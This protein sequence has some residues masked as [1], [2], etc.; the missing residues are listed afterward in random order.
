MGVRDGRIF[1][2]FLLEKKRPVVKKTGRAV[3]MD[4][5]YVNGFVFSDGQNVGQELVEKI[6]GFAKRTKHTHQLI[7]DMVGAELKKIDLSQIY[8]LVIEDLKW[9]KNG[10]RGKF[11]RQMNRRMSHKWP[12]LGPWL[13]AY[14]ADW[15]ARCCEEARVRLESGPSR[16]HGPFEGL[17]QRKNPAYTSQYCR[18]CNKWDRRNRTGDKFVCVSCG[19][20]D[21]ADKNASKNLELLGL[22]GVY[23][24][25]LLQ[26]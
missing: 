26:S 7:K 14:V 23:G 4:S 12:P 21:H 15:L 13:Y 20:A 8:M 17:G 16:P 19:H 9:V 10:K 18:H 5:N 11:S 1:I 25:R 24:L 2:D 6:R 3:G 22:A